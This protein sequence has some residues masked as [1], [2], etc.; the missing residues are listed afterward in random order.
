M[1]IFNEKIRNFLET[2]SKDEDRDVAIV[3]RSLSAAV[4]GD[5]LFFRY[6]IDNTRDYRIVMAVTPIVRDAATGNLLVTCFKLPEDMDFEQDSLDNL[7]KERA[8][9]WRKKRVTNLTSTLS[10]P[11]HGYRTY[12]LT[13]GPGNCIWG[14]IYRIRKTPT[15]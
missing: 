12:I 6:E 11:F 7:Y 8:E 5:I 4:P 14:N 10:Q 3:P 15:E 9:N 2:A 1:G 13:K